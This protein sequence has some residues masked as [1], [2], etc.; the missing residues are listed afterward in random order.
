MLGSRYLL[1][2]KLGGGS[3]GEIYVAE[4]VNTSEEVAVK[5]EMK[6]NKIQLLKN[7]S[8]IYR[9]LQGGV[10]IPNIKYY[11][12]DDNQN[13]LVMDLLGKSLQTLFNEND[14]SFSIKTVL[15]I[16]DQMITRVEYLHHKNL[17][18]R[19]IKPD[20]FVIGKGKKSNQIYM[21]D[22]GI[23]KPYCDRYTHEHIKFCTGK[24]VSG[25]IRYTSIN[26]HMGHEQSRRDDLE[27]VAY[28]LVYL[29]KG[30]LP[31]INVQASNKTEKNQMIRDLK[32]NTPIEKICE[33]IPQEFADFLSSV[34]S[35]SF[36]EKPDYAKYRKMFRKLF[37]RENFVYDFQYDWMLPKQ[38]KV[39]PQPA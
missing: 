18:H 31:W 35:L 20:N 13:A 32:I 24:S 22:M 14:K 30:T 17:I 28:V 7:E 37:I 23:S 6:N 5:V 3:F 12:S 27:S 25:T 38:T 36:E 11:G 21:I 15:M 8:A 9:L 26:S 39:I 34:R 1:G 4:N 33:G 19:D 10:G 29:L 16:A 2:E